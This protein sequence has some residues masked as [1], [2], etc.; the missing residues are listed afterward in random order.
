MKKAGNTWLPDG[1]E[2][3]PPY[4]E[5][6]DV[7]EGG[8][9]LAAL[10]HVRTFGVAVDGGAHVGSWSRF[11][12]GFFKEVYAYEPHPQ[13]FECLM[14]NCGQYQNVHCLN[15]ALGKEYGEMALAKGNNGGCWY[16]VE[17][18][19]VKVIPLP[20]FGALDFLKL[21]IE[22]FEADVI[23]GGMKLIEKYRPV[24][25][26]EEKNLP[27]K[28]LDYS[29]RRLLEK[30]DYREVARSGRDVVFA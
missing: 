29:A 25:L 11:M 17:G 21:D 2:F 16:K 6:S 3:F 26:I 30:M 24:V 1:D 10:K 19:G 23:E 13:N 15:V 9:L 22:G 28:R 12:A 5:K 7:F 27:H 18:S 8:N 4:F 20:D 14:A